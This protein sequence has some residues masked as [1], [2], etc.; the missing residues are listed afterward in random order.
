MKGKT[1]LITGTTNGLGKAT[2]LALAKKGAK[3]IMVNR[4]SHKVQQARQEIIKKSGNQ[5]VASMLCDL[6]SQASIREFGQAFREQYDSLDVLINNAGALFGERQLTEDGIERTFALN[7]LG[8][9]QVAHYLL[10]ALK[11]GNAPRIVNVSSVT[12]NLN[13]FDLD[14]LQGQKSYSQIKHYGMTKLCNILFTKFLAQKMQGIMTVNCLHPGTVGTGFGKETGSL[15]MRICVPIATPFMIRPNKGA[16]TS[17]YLASSPKVANITGEYFYKKKITETTDSAKDMQAAQAL[18]DY[19]LKL[20][21]IKEFGKANF[22][23]KTKDKGQ[24]TF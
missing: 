23:Q 12:H 14:N 21:K 1:V 17:I 24:K 20:T 2:A 19:S 16:E 13:D 11:K 18:W 9:F 7:H 5:E 8:Y 6:S 4:P 15:W 22:G 3:I 10:D